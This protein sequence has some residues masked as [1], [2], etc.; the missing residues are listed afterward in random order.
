MSKTNT[1]EWEVVSLGHV[2][3]TR[4]KC[5]FLWFRLIATYCY[6]GV[7]SDIYNFCRGSGT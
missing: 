2:T 4:V 1:L 5:L 3:I 7:W 6:P